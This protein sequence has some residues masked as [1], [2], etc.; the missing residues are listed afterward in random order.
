MIDFTKDNND[1]QGTYIPL[2]DSGCISS[3]ELHEGVLVVPVLGDPTKPPFI[4]RV[5]S[6]YTI[7]RM[8]YKQAKSNAPPLIP[9]PATTRSGHQFLG[10]SISI[11]APGPSEN[12]M[13]FQVTCDYNFVVPTHTTQS[14]KIMWDAHPYA[15]GIDMWGSELTGQISS[16]PELGGYYNTWNSQ[17]F[18]L[19]KLTSQ[20]ILG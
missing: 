17:Y 4:G 7:R 15:T 16:D 18:E 6:P 10:G 20:K 8:R 13:I 5:H 12:G 3:Y 11:P 19:D 2:A 1:L 14:G 9:P